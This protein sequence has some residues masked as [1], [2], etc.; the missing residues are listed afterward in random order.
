MNLISTS[1]INIS[2]NLSIDCVGTTT[3]INVQDLL[4]NPIAVIASTNTVQME[5]NNTLMALFGDKLIVG[6][7]LPPIVPPFVNPPLGKTY[8]VR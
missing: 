7:I 8:F 3:V 4:N 2:Y 1:N 6:P 5:S